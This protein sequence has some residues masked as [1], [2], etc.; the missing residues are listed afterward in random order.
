TGSYRSRRPRAAAP[1]APWPR[2]RRPAPGPR[3][4]RA[5]AGA[6]NAGRSRSEGRRLGDLPMPDELDPIARKYPSFDAAAPRNAD[7]L[8]AFALLEDL[9][10]PRPGEQVNPQAGQVEP[11]LVDNPRLP[12]D[13]TSEAMIPKEARGAARFVAR[14]AGVIAGLPVLELIARSLGGE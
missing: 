11:G 7:Y 2:P 14:S 13:L 8:F 9:G 5:A 10:Y 12:G 1:R 4:R 3:P 6:A